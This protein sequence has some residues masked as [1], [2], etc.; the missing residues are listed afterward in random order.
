MKLTSAKF[1]Q[2][3]KLDTELLF[4]HEDKYNI[5][6]LNDI[7]LKITHKTRDI[8]TYT[9]LMNVCW[10]KMEDKKSGASTTD[11]RSSSKK[12]K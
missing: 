11:A 10:W 2:A 12:N 9:S 1:S 8:T 5:E 3:V 6:L 7:H 4:V